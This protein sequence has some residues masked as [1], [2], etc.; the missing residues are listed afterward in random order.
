MSVDFTIGN[1]VNDQSSGPQ[2]PTDGND[3][4]VTLSS[5]ELDG[6]ATGFETFLAGLG[7]SA[8]QKAFAVDVDAGSNSSLIGVTASADE[9]INDLKLLADPTSATGWT[10]LAGAALY[11]HVDATGNYATLTTS[12]GA[13]GT[14]YA[15]FALTNEVINNVAH[16]ASAGVQM[17]TFAPI[18]HGDD[19]DPDDTLALGDVLKVAADTAVSFNF[20]QLAAGNFLWA[21]VGNS[22]SAMLITGQDLNVIDT[23]GKL[24]EKVNSGSSDPTDTVNTSKATDTTIGI[25]AQ[26][27]APTN[28]GDGGVCVFTFV[29]GLSQLELATP[30]YTGQNIQQIDYDNYKNVSSASIFV[31]QLTGSGTAK[32]KISLVEAGG[33]GIADHLTSALLPEEGYNADATNK[34]SYIGN[35]DTDSNLKDDTPVNVGM[36]TITRNGTAHSIT[37]TGTIAALGIT[38]TFS[39]NSVVI[40][41]ALANDLVGLVAANDPS[42][43][44]D[45][46]FN[47]IDVQALF[48]SAS[49]DIG[50]ID[51]TSGGT[52]SDDLGSYLYV[53]DDGPAI[54]PSADLAAPN[55]LQ[56]G[57]VVGA[58]DDSAYVLKPGTDGQKSFAF[59]GDADSS[60][61]FTFV[62][63]DASHTS[64][65]GRYKGSELYTLVLNPDGS[66]DFD[67]TGTL[68]GST[69]DLNPAEVIKAGAP[70]APILEV[71]AKQN[72]D[73][74][75]MSASGGNINESH[76]FVGVTNGNIDIG[77][78]L[79]FT[80]FD[81]D[82]DPSTADPMLTFQGI[83]IGTKSA[84]GGTYTVLYHV[85]GD[86]AGQMT[87]GAN[88]TVAKNGVINID[89]TDLGGATIDSIT[90]GKISG[91]AI[92]IGIADI[93]IIIEPDDVQ[94][95]FSVELKDGDNDPA[96]AS[97]VVDIDGNNDGLFDATVNAALASASTLSKEWQSSD[98][99]LTDLDQ[100]FHHQVD[101]LLM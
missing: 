23:P 33:G 58:H 50:H 16:T 10:T 52:S 100:A 41:G 12:T 19:T 68:P 48:G 49:F 89:S 95:G 30:Q 29:E 98:A 79:T 86:P 7:L 77:E 66:Y 17:V 67:M 31:S 80:L 60:G 11:L 1:L 54:D 21:A 88:E 18:S 82:G 71:G 59:A 32:M 76:G 4:D 56:V 74:V 14:I 44:L 13:G 8:A 26:H 5:N 63:D 92:K 42:T 93:H 24:G 36:V 81:G 3:I 57:N 64:I 99:S 22:G 15:A 37:S 87:Q 78:S 75:R 91:S 62:F 25:N 39:G 53:D 35:Q 72:D 85:F 69:L 84:Q 6:L 61:D 43:N 20:S 101:Y 96:T 90:V 46:T 47:R 45:G 9:F 65:T 70:D 97:F 38:V 83:Q 94:L 51:L 34:F 55:D 73:Y 28:T 2:T 27:F 40:D